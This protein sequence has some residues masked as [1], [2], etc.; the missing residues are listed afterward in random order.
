MHATILQLN[1]IPCKCTNQSMSYLT[2]LFCSELKELCIYILRYLLRPQ[3]LP[4]SKG[5]Y[6]HNI[7]HN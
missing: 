7:Y 1:L 6:T 2:I 5:L 4:S 3:T